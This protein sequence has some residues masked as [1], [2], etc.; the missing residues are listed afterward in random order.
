[1]TPAQTIITVLIVGVCAI[2]VLALDG[3]PMPPS[4]G[5]AA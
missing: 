5:A 1:M 2:I 3:P 4:G